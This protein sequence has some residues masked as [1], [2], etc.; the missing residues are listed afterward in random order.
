MVEENI[1]IKKLAFPS[2]PK[3]GSLDGISATQAP[4]FIGS[5]R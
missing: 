3:E 5:V 1:S 4:L 2:G